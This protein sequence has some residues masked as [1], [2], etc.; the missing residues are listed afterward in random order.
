MTKGM[1]LR[2]IVVGG[3]AA[4]MSAASQVKRRIKTAEV[5]VLEKTEDVSYG[6][7]GMPYNIGFRG[8]INDLVV[9][10]AGD[11]R[12]KRGIDVRLLN[13]AVD[14]D[15]ENNKIFVKNIA[16]EREYELEYDYLVIA[17]G[18]KALNPKIDGVNN[19][20]VFTLKTLDDARIM[21]KYIDNKQPKRCVLIGGG[22]INLEMAENFRKLGMED[23]TVLKRREALLPEY[24]DEIDEIAKEELRKN[25]VKLVT[26]VNLKNIDTSLN[27]QTNKGTFPSDIINIAIG[28]KPNTEFIQNTSIETDDMGAIVVDRY[29]K[30][31]IENIYSGGDCALIYNRILKRNSYIPRG[32]NANKAGKI[33]GI[34]ITGGKEEFAGVVGTSA[35]KCFETTIGKTG[36]SLK[37]AQSEGYNAFKTAISAQT[38][39]HGYPYQGKITVIFI[40]EKGSGRLLGAQMIGDETVALRIDV[41]ATALYSNM[42]IKD[43]Q[44]LDLVYSPPFAPVWDPILVCANQAIKRV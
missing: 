43:I 12:E 17:T 4:G 35:F 42:T 40:A 2:V 8:D 3:D 32:N 38:R 24:E 14:L 11:F 23:I 10:R 28:V 41:M 27:V 34:N 15:I 29:F 33:A 37:E 18:A 20:G 31:N 9:M 25:G 39:A 22:F 19:K 5:T 30:T 26:G 21:K 36:L 16:S 13:E 44:G 6:A 1:P 7:C